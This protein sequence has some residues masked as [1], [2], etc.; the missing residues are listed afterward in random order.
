MLLREATRFGLAAAAIVALAASAQ[1]G[2]TLRV[3]LTA[4]DVPT[5]TGAPDNGGEGLRWPHWQN[6]RFD[7]LIDRI[8]KSSDP[9]GIIGD[10]QKAHEVFVDDRPWLFIVHDRN[11]RAMTKHVKG[12]VSAQSWF[13]D[14]TPVSME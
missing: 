4:T 9:E 3:T 7:A 5:T 2:G 11:A 14:F 12:F 1:A 13:Q 6:P 10:I 8:E